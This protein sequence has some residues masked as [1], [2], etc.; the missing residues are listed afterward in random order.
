MSFDRENHTLPLPKKSILK[1]SQESQ[2]DFDASQNSNNNVDI[3]NTIT[4]VSL[5]DEKEHY[6]RD[7]N[8]TSRINLV[9]KRKISFAPDVTLHSFSIIKDDN[10]KSSPSSENKR[11]S[12]STSQNGAEFEDIGF[13]T[14]T[15]VSPNKHSL[16]HL[17]TTDD[18]SMDLTQLVSNNTIKMKNISSTNYITNND[19]MELTQ[20]AVE[21]PIN[22]TSNNNDGN[23]M[24][25]TQ[26]SP[27]VPNLL[28]NKDAVDN[29]TMEFTQIA[30]TGSQIRSPNKT[31][32]IGSGGNSTTK[33][34]ETS[35]KFIPNN[36]TNT[37]LTEIQLI[38]N[39]THNNIQQKDLTME[40]TE[41][42]KIITSPANQNKNIIDDKSRQTNLSSTSNSNEDTENSME[43]TQ[44]QLPTIYNKTSNTVINVNNDDHTMEFTQLQHTNSQI[45]NDS[46]EI[47]QLQSTSTTIKTPKKSLNNNKSDN[48]ITKKR[49]LNTPP[50]YI[51]PSHTA[52]PKRQHKPS[53][54]LNNSDTSD[55]LNKN[56]PNNNSRRDSDINLNQME[57][58]S[59]VKI[60]GI[61][62]FIP[63]SRKDL[64]T[65]ITDS[66][67]TQIS[68]TQ[69]FRDIECNLDI[70]S[71]NIK[72]LSNTRIKFPVDSNNNKNI[73]L[74]NCLIN[75][76]LNIP[77]IEINSLIC[78]ELT[79]KINQS[80]KEFEFLNEQISKQNIDNLPNLLKSFYNCNNVE[81]KKKLIKD[82]SLTKDIASLNAHNDWLVWHTNNLINVNENLNENISILKERLKELD[83]D[84]QTANDI[85][86]DV[87]NLK[88]Q[89]MT[90]MNSLKNKLGTNTT[91]PNVSYN[92]EL[93]ERK[94]ELIRLKN[95][96][97]E[98][99]IKVNDLSVLKYEKNKLLIKLSEQNRLLSQ[100]NSKANNNNNNSMEKFL[101]LQNLTQIKL[102]SFVDYFITIKFI[103]KIILDEPIELIL[104]LNI[105]NSTYTI[106]VDCSDKSTKSFILSYF[107]TAFHQIK[108]KFDNNNRLIKN[109]NLSLIKSFY[110]NFWESRKLLKQFNLINYLFDTNIKQEKD[111]FFLQLIDKDFTHNATPVI[112]Q[113]SLVELFY[114]YENKLLTFD[115]GGLPEIQVVVSVQQSKSYPNDS[116]LRD[117]LQLRTS[118][119]VPWFSNKSLRMTRIEP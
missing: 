33:F 87:M 53:I 81:D 80:K 77:M 64:K 68:L 108:L 56:L 49:K 86:L 117:R 39:A 30:T 119:I 8:T 51:D 44:L 111:K 43:F 93:I 41:I 62:D 23:T 76:Y 46:M 91:L 112:Y 20:L 25:L 66:F 16:L 102:I 21:T 4:D 36:E 37:E 13:A 34:S 48:I 73:R 14:S 90:K 114:H 15:Q 115:K 6:E 60:K 2:F 67:P 11:N 94:I 75:L 38:H 7:N 55:S 96:F 26:I 95:K 82:L 24:E 88:D 103:E 31:Q 89:I 65:K 35:S 71:F 69:F 9:S 42:P 118:R 74:K 50:R 5:I 28:E 52:I 54:E 40:F 84:L 45:K 1:Q 17:E 63:S 29:N 12:E 110:Q 109:K 58:L 99:K 104:K 70:D 100:M 98:Q 32:D 3:P 61:N 10:G 113:I 47:T 85:K 79:S 27:I 97:K 92:S 105:L 59:P 22:G 19:T 78:N 83:K 116:I 57:R 107:Q 101:A 72:S 18:T 106:S